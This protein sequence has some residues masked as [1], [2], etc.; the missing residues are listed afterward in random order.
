MPNMKE[1]KT[2]LVLFNIHYFKDEKGTYYKKKGDEHRIMVRPFWKMKR[3][4]FGIP[5][6]L[7]LALG[8]AGYKIGMSLASEKMVNEL[9]SQMTK[10]DYD[11]LL[12][13]PSVQQIVAKELGS[14]QKSELLNN[15][16]SDSTI[17]ENNGQDT[18]SVT[19]NESGKETENADSNKDK[20]TAATS[21]VSNKDQNRATSEDKS[22]DT[23]NVK[24]PSEE[25]V[26]PGLQFSS[27]QEVMKFLLSKFSMGELSV[28]AKKAQGGVTAQEKEEIKNTVLGRLST[29]EYNALKVYAAINISKRQ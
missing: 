2:P 16:S 27:N 17:K 29:E 6:L 14:D 21:P 26:E 12:K 8:L 3:I 28:L 7:V 24:Q 4:K 20:E 15:L 11:N 5:V 19:N 23:S 9:A 1:I 25:K 13:D 10:E 22:K 18:Q